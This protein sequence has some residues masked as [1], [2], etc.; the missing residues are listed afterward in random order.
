MPIVIDIKTQE[1][2]NTLEDFIRSD[3]TFHEKSDLKVM[4]KKL[5]DSHVK[6]LWIFNILYLIQ[7]FNL[8]I[9]IIWQVRGVLYLMVIFAIILI[10]IEL[11]QM[12]IQKW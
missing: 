3:R 5:F 10:F 4:I 6:L 8:S 2:R 12:S 7:A 1:C 9:L 11:I